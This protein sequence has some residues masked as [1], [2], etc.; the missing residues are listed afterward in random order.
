MDLFGR[1]AKKRAELNAKIA[2]AFLLMR[3]GQPARKGDTAADIFGGARY[4]STVVAMDI[5][6]FVKRSD[7]GEPLYALF[8][9]ILAIYNA[10]AALY[11]DGGEFDLL[12]TPQELVFLDSAQTLVSTEPGLVVEAAALIGGRLDAFLLGMADKEIDRRRAAVYR[13]MALW[14]AGIHLGMPMPNVRG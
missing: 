10:R 4:A 13:L 7:R 14:Q 12:C 8:E 11:F 6:E 1:Q 5:T 3:N 9:C 2:A